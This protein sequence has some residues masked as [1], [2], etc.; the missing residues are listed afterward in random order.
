MNTAIP[1]AHRRHLPIEIALPG[2]VGFL[3]LMS[4]F[5]ATALPQVIV[6]VGVPSVLF[7][8]LVTG[9]AQ[10]SK[11]RLAFLSLWLGCVGI[12]LLLEGGAL[13][14]LNVATALLTHSPLLLLVLH[15]R[16]EPKTYDRLIGLLATIAV[17]EVGLAILQFLMNNGSLSFRSMSAGDA[18]V[19]TL[20][21]NSHMF[22][23]KMLVLMVILGVAAA[24]R[25]RTVQ[26]LV[27]AFA[28]LFGVFLGSA[29][30]A[31]IVAVGAIGTTILFFPS[32]V[33]P[34]QF[35]IAIK[36][37]RRWMVL[38]SLVL[39]IGM[40][41]LQ[42]GNV[43]YVLNTLTRASELVSVADGGSSSGKIVGWFG[44][45]D[46]MRSNPKVLL[47]GTGLGQYSSR[48]ALILSGGYL[49]SHPEWV[50]VSMS[51]YTSSFILPL[52]N[53]SVWSVQF[54]DG[55]MNQPFFGLQS[56]LVES[57]VVGFA[58]LGAGYLFIGAAL[59]RTAAGS[60]HSAAILSTAIFM[61]LLLPA[62]LLTDNWLEFPH[63]AIG[64]LIPITMALSLP[65]RS[66][67]VREGTR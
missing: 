34:P 1:A 53:R 46:L 56:I 10:F 57:G 9:R 67:P 54:Q 31:M 22:V 40:A 17:V 7:A 43:Q 14:P 64:L 32:A 55:V 45:M 39:V 15:L 33:L 24:Y 47:I 35:L 37:L 44:S 12:S 36:R 16:F 3:H 21:T 8:A 50:P 63:A 41:Y 29:L 30:L 61:Y 19:G 20:L 59:L 51:H 25:I 62:L 13:Q 4:W 28:A 60:R 23:V 42:R 65:P 18:A 2:L 48:A 27:G 11:N 49:H 5:P 26:A 6:Y 52:W 38:G 58:I 66:A